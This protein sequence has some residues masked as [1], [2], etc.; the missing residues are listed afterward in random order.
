MR[1]QYNDGITV[2]D[3]KHRENMRKGSER[4]LHE[5]QQWHPEIIRQLTKG[6]QQ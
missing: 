2:N 3:L 4:L 5:L 6:K 1:K